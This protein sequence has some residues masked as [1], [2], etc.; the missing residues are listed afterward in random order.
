MDP[1]LLRFVVSVLIALDALLTPCTFTVA[2]LFNPVA[3]LVKSCVLTDCENFDIEAAIWLI[4]FARFEN[5]PL[6]I[7]PREPDSFVSDVA[8]RF[9][10][11]SALFASADI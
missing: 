3:I 8:K 9:I 5:C 2:N 11:A 7:P 4:P 1:I 6:V 10:A